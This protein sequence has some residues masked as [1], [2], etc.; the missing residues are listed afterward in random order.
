MGVDGLFLDLLAGPAQVGVQGLLG[1]WG[2][3]LRDRGQQQL[4]T[5]VLRVGGQGLEENP[6][7][8]GVGRRYPSGL[9]RGCAWVWRI[10]LAA[11]T[12]A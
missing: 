7:L 5:D 11:V 1:A 6:F 4:A 12:A 8:G 10:Q 3:V 2:V 9:T